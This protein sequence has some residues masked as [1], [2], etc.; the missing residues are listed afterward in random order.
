MGLE[1]HY[2]KTLLNSSKGG[3]LDEFIWIFPLKKSSLSILSNN[4]N[5]PCC[6]YVVISFFSTSPQCKDVDFAPLVENVYGIPHFISNHLPF[7]DIVTKLCHCQEVWVTF[8]CRPT[9]QQN[10]VHFQTMCKLHHVKL[11]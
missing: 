8:H 2:S 6:T 3:S 11:L 10:F 4:T 9:P 7:L 5:T 1:I